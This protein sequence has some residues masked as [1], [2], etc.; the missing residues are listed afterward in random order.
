MMIQDIIDREFGVHTD[1]TEAA[2]TTAMTTTGTRILPF[3]G[4]RLAMSIINTGSNPVLILNGPTVSS[5]K[6]IYIPANGGI[7][8]M[9]VRNDFNLPAQEW[10][11]LTTTS[12]S[13][14]AVLTVQIATK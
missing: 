13:T 1:E 12:T 4:G 7:L 11:G 14:I 3:N 9:T 10:W 8:S 6:G 2:I 5:T